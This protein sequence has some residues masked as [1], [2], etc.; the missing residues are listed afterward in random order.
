MSITGRASLESQVLPTAKVRRSRDVAKARRA[1]GVRAAS[2]RSYAPAGLRIAFTERQIQ[3]RVA[4]MARRIRQDYRGRTLHIVTLLENSFMFL[5]DLTRQL[6]TVVVCHFLQ[7]QVK[8]RKWHGLPLHEIKYAP[9][10]PL[11][12]KDVLLLEGVLQT[13]ITEDFLLR[14]IE[15]QQPHSLRTATLIEKAAQRKVSLTPDYV[16]FQSDSRFLVG[17]GLSFNGDYACLP[18]IAELK[19][20]NS[21]P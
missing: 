13:G 10:A 14:S 17:Y 8:D 9:S 12:G 16:G 19:G 2:S 5:A 18:Y 7:A 15:D 11:G 4:Q 20:V 21:N 1:S 6:E 3:H